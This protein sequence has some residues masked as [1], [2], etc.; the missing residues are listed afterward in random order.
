MSGFY[1]ILSYNNNLIG[2]DDHSVTDSNETR[3]FDD[4]YDERTK[5]NRIRAVY[6][7]PN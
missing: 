2:G 4:G 3:A 5:K 6:M 7:P 1:Q